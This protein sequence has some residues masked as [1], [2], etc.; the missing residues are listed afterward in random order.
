MKVLSID[1][2]PQAKIFLILQRIEVILTILKKNLD[3]TVRNSGGISYKFS[4]AGENFFEDCKEM[5]IFDCFGQ[6]LGKSDEE[7]LDI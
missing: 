2:A 7:F 6:N 4:A 3:K 5:R 1:L